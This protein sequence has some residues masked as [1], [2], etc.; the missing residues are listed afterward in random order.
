MDEREQIE[1]Y[2]FGKL[3]GEPLR[4]FEARL[5][6]DPDFAKMVRQEVEILRALRLSSSVEAL[7]EQLKMIENEQVNSGK[8]VDSPT[9]E[10]QTPLGNPGKRTSSFRPWYGWMAAAALVLLAV[11]VVFLKSKKEVLTPEQIFAAHFK[12]PLRLT[13]AERSAE[14]AGQVTQNEFQ[15]QWSEAKDLY[16]KGDFKAALEKWK[17][18]AARQEAIDYQDDIGFYAGLTALQASDFRTA[19][20]FFETISDGSYNAEK[21]W[22]LA[23]AQLRAG[24][25]AAAKKG[26]EQI[27]ASGSPFT[28]EARVI[29]RHLSEH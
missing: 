9:S 18:L 2:T 20:S 12:P 19:I 13:S 27:A 1:L 7:R 3:F 4:D 8:E 28:E 26:F 6:A 24:D 11:A 21:P 15:K 22:Y 5:A 14:T 25:I 29:L 17:S 23:L 10:T 16:R